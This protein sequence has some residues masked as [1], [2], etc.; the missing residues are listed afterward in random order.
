MN[1]V[2]LD[3]VSTKLNNPS[4]LSLLSQS[5]SLCITSNEVQ[6]NLRGVS[7]FLTIKARLVK[8]RG[9]GG[10]KSDIQIETPVKQLVNK[11]LS[12]DKV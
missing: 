9:K 1:V 3:N 5:L 10:G 8:F 4:Q 11:A 6:P 7:F 12:I 2:S